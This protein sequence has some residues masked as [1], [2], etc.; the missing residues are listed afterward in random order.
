[1]L[2]QQLKQLF[3]MLEMIPIVFKASKIFIFS[4]QWKRQ[5]AFE[6]VGHTPYFRCIKRD[7]KQCAHANV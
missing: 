1:M 4:I 7:D 3:S 6:C 5:I 2:R